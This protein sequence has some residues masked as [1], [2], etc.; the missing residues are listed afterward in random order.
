MTD[1]DE[2]NRFF[3]TFVSRDNKMNNNL[4]QE[5]KSV[6]II[7]NINVNTKKNQNQENL[8]VKNKINLNK[9]GYFD[10]IYEQKSSKNNIVKKSVIPN[11]LDEKL[12]QNEEKKLNRYKTYADLKQESNKNVKIEQKKGFFEK[13]HLNKNIDHL[14]SNIFQTKLKSHYDDTKDNFQETNILYTETLSPRNSGMNTKSKKINFMYNSTAFQQLNQTQTVN[15]FNK[16]RNFKRLYAVDNYLGSQSVTNLIKPNK[17]KTD[18]F[19]YKN[20]INRNDPTIVSNFDEKVK[21][22]AFT[23]HLKN[24]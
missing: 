7:S 3:K 12:V 2:S 17:N 22:H 21:K 1:F 16:N 18:E 24:L 8:V 23:H 19:V 4:S 6:S 13:S 11:R 15:E 5:N 9:F 20:K 10:K 14:K